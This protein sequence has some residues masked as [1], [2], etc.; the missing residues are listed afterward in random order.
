M[1]RKCRVDIK[2]SNGIILPK[3]THIGVAAGANALDSQYF[4]KPDEFDGFRFEKL[5]ALPGND[6]KYQV[7]ELEQLRICIRK[8]FSF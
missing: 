4:D 3:G 1:T 7:G 2:L 8:K 5:R 6:N